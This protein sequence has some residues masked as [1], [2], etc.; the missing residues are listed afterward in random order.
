MKIIKNIKQ[1][2]QAAKIFSQYKVAALYESETIQGDSIII[3]Y[4]PFYLTDMHQEHLKTLSRFYPYSY[5]HLK[6]LYCMYWRKSLI[7]FQYMLDD[8]MIFNDIHYEYLLDKVY[9]DKYDK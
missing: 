3:D 4:D 2:V 1:A 7:G 6:Y 9:G 5:K 8:A